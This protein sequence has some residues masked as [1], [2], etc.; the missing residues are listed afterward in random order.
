MELRMQKP[1]LQHYDDGVPPALTYPDMTLPQFLA[2]TA[3]DHPDY[4]ATTLSGNDI[5]YAALN[6]KVNAFARALQ[7]MGIVRGQKLAPPL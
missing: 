7:T 4:I 5:S 6:R 3:A 2:A 1:W